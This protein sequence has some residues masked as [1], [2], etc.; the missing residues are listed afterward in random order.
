MEKLLISGQARGSTNTTIKIN[1]SFYT[2]STFMKIPKLL[3]V[4]FLLSSEL[5]IGQNTRFSQI[6]SAPMLLN[7]ALTGRF[8]GKIRLAG[9]Y[10]TATAETV[11]DTSHIKAKM[12]TRILPLILN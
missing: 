4:I 8:D 1:L 5:V 9:L 6:G 3:V 2:K 7:P 11:T 10:S 12:N